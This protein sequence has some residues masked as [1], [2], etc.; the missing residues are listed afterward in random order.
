MLT[1]MPTGELACEKTFPGAGLYDLVRVGLR[2]RLH[3]A[4]QRWYLLLSNDLDR[5]VVTRDHTQRRVIFQDSPGSHHDVRP[6][7]QCRA[8][9]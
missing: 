6:E 4:E 9:E 3:R 7:L 8:H 5:V 2:D 1:N